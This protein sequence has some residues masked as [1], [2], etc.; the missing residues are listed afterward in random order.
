MK[1]LKKCILSLIMTAALL[2]SMFAVYQPAKVL[3]A[4]G[5]AEKGYIRAGDTKIYSQNTGEVNNM[6]GLS[7]DK[8]S[9]TLTINDFNHPDW[10]I[11]MSDM[12]DIKVVVKGTC[13]LTRLVHISLSNPLYSNNMSLSGNGKLILKDTAASGIL[14]CVGKNAKISMSSEISVDLTAGGGAISIS[15]DAGDGSADLLAIKGKAPNYKMVNGGSGKYATGASYESYL[16]DS[17]TFIKTGTS[18]SGSGS[19]SSGVKAPG[20]VKI[21]S[22]KNKSSNYP[23]G[24]VI[25]WKKI[26]NI[27]G[28][29]VQGSRTKSFKKPNMWVNMYIKPKFSDFHFGTRKGA[30]TYARVRA[31]RRSNG[32]DYYG[33]WSKVVKIKAK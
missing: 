19:G 15:R 31:Y 11:T 14:C 33:S 30:V 26:S 24:V 20:K 23:H 17:K 5:P 9:N 7:Y 28:Y 25:K 16:S 8:N 21:T 12:G 2:V 13:K 10:R 6:S 3:A 4:T 1:D 22:T 32:K 18:G 29:Q 27:Y